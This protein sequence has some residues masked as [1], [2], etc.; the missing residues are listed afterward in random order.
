[1]ASE[2]RNEI[3]IRECRLRDLED[4]KASQRMLEQITILSFLAIFVI[5]TVENISFLMI[6]AFLVILTIFVVVKNREYKKLEQEI[7]R[8]I[9][10]DL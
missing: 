9:K 3:A 8:E 7:K 2:D 5:Y 6:A 10:Q 4:V 1:M